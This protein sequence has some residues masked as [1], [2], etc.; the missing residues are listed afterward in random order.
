MTL[1]AELLFKVEVAWNGSVNIGAPG[2]L[3][4]SHFLSPVPALRLL[5]ASAKA[6][7]LPLAGAP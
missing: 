4:R 6:R 7:V 3:Q 5:V 1:R 2:P